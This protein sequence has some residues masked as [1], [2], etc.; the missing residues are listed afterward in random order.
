[1]TI[2]TPSSNQP[3]WRTAV[4]YQVYPRSFADANGDGMGDLRGVIN[5]LPYLAELGVD[6]L[7]LNPFYRS[8]QNDAGYDVADYDTVDPIFGSTADAEELIVAAH[9]LNLKVIFDIVPNHTSSEHAWFQQALTTAPGTG[10]WDRYHCV[11]G[12]GKN[13]TEPPNDWRSVF[14]GPAWTQIVNDADQEPTGWGYLHLFDATQPDVNWNSP[15]VR[16]EHERVLT[17]WFDRG[18][19]GFRIDVAHGLVKTAGYPDSG[20]QERVLGIDD[21]VPVLPQWDQPGVH[22]VYRS[23]RQLA[24][25]YTP[26]RMFCGEALVSTPEAH[27]QYLREDELHTAFN[28]HYLRTRWDAPHLKETIDHSLVTAD[29]VG[30]P[31]TWV[32]SNHDVRRHVTRLAPRDENGGYDTGVG[33]QRARAASLI[34]LALPGSAYLYQGEELGL[35]EVLDLPDERRQDPVFIRTGGQSLGRDG[36]RVPLPWT[37]TGDTFG[38]SS[39]HASWLPQPDYFAELSVDAQ[40]GDPDSTLEMYRR[41]LALRAQSSAMH[42]PRMRWLDSGEDV[43]RFTRLGTRSIEVA[44]NLGREDVIIPAAELLLGSSPTVTFGDSHITLPPNTAVWLT[45]R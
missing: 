13:G 35:P 3:W 27:A 32:L 31:C 2:D 24:D 5:H 44:A 37:S 8:P 36:C 6:A 26:P 19:D 10:I 38:F 43:I 4:I 33:V 25:S 9:N 45:P 7:W 39:G 11:R 15:A 23:W 28:F 22:D 17:Y 20:E 12:S 21:D 40:D 41:A 30:A 29:S 14:G 1:M 18:V 34:M 16:A 42:S